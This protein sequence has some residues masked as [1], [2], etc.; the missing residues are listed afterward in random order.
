[1][2]GQDNP[3]SKRQIFENIYHNCHCHRNSKGGEN[4]LDLHP[5]GVAQQLAWEIGIEEIAYD[6]CEDRGVEHRE[7]SY[8]SSD[9]QWG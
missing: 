8:E 7:D 3:V 5:R 9:K 1:M 2:Y 6:G 4:I